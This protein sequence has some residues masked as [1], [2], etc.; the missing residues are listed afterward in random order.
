MTGFGIT[1]VEPSGSAVGDLVN[2]EPRAEV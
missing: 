2:R 1:S